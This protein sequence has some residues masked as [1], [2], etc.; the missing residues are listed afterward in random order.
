MYNKLHPTQT[1]Q[2]R[3]LLLFRPLKQVSAT[4]C[5]CSR[6][7]RRPKRALRATIFRMCLKYDVLKGMFPWRTRCPLG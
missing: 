2:K 6:R 3:L 5:V 7:R 1:L 4:S